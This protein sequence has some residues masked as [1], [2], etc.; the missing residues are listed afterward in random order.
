MKQ[1]NVVLFP[2]PEGPIKAVIRF[3]G[4]LRLSFRN[5]VFRSYEKRSIL[6]SRMEIPFCWLIVLTVAASAVMET[7]S[8]E[9]VYHEMAEVIGSRDNWPL[10]SSSSASMLICGK[11]SVCVRRSTNGVPNIKSSAA[12]TTI[13]DPRRAR[14]TIDIELR[15]YAALSA[16]FKLSFRRSIWKRGSKL[17]E[18]LRRRIKLE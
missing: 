6:A 2:H 10:C 15:A 9:T 13:E 16:P 8:F 5:T 12:T 14:W 1:R 3:L 11:I 17:P 18:T 7:L 4:T